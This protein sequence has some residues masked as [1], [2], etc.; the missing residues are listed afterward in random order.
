MESEG[1]SVHRFNKDTRFAL[2]AAE[3][4]ARRRGDRRIG[5]EHL[6]LGVLVVPRSEWIEILGAD[7]E[8]ARA[9]L[10]A[11]DRN[12][13]AE[14]GMEASG[15]LPLRPIRTEGRLRLTSGAM[16]VLRGGL[17]EA[18][19]AKARSI[20]P[21]HLLLALL[22]ADGPH[23]AGQLLATLGIDPEVVRA[24]MTEAA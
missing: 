10:A 24:R 13:L 12:A 14:L 3:E 5:T 6:L 18:T 22:A 21:R 15:L 19:R 16:K 4:E 20:E 17:D 2:K 7:L 11:M 8:S 1:W 23:A 9:A